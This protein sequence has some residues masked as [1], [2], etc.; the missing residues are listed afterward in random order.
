MK[1]QWVATQ[2]DYQLRQKSQIDEKGFQPR[3]LRLHSDE[4]T[5][6][7]YDFTDRIRQAA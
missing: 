5:Y 7:Q 1:V 6:T 4:L 3:S 2:R